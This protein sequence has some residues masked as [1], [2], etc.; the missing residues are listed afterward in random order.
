MKSFREYGEDGTGYDTIAALKKLGHGSNV[1]A[2]VEGRKEPDKHGQC[3][4]IQP[5]PVGHTHA[6]LIGRADGADDLLARDA[7]G[8]EGRAD[9]PPPTAGSAA[10]GVGYI[11]LLGCNFAI[12][13]TSLTL[14]KR[15]T[16]IG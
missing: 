9:D 7:R 14:L 5:F 11:A 1:A 12:M 16:M 6:V 3:R 15:C 8:N 4:E 2:N 13:P 10:V